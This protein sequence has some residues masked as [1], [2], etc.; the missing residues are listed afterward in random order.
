[1][2]SQRA[3]TSYILRAAMR[4][5]RLAALGVCVELVQLHLLVANEVSWEAL[6]SPLD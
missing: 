5:C 4:S 3:V 2:V 1:V 6:R